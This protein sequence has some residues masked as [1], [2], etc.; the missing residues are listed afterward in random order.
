MSRKTEDR[1]DLIRDAKAY[2]RRVE[3]CLDLHRLRTIVFAGFRTNGAVS[4]YFDTDPV[5]HFNPL[6]ELRRAFVDNQII[7]AE[8]RRLVRWSTRRTETQ[9]EMLRDVLPETQQKEFCRTVH[10]TLHALHQGLC[11]SKPE[12]TRQVPAEGDVIAD[13]QTWLASP[14]EVRIADSPRVA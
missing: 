3:F 14:Q 4:I 7:K 9:V 5:Y 8:Q 2:S 10:G 6:G 1:E 12:M 13:L 11:K